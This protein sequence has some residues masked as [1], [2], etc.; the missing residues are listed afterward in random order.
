MARSMW[1]LFE[2][3]HAV[4][5]FAAEAR[6]AYEQAGLRGFWRGYF[7]GRAAPLGVAGAGGTV[8]APAGT[9]TA[10]AGTAGAA[11][12]AA[13][14][15]NFA[16]A[17]VARAIPGVWDLITPE[18]ALRVRLAGATEGLGRLLAGQEAEAAAA[19]DLLWRAIGELDF[20]GR[21]LAAANAALPVL[22]GEDVAVSSASSASLAAAA[23]GRLWQAATLLREH[24]GDGHFA[25][26]AAADIDGCEAVVLRCCL[27]LR[28]EDMQPVRG[29]TDEAWDG[30]LS[31]LAAR[32]WV[33]A[34]GVL[35]SAGREAHAAVE[36]A[37]D[38]AA[39][40]PWARLGPEATAEIAAALTPLAR[41]C[42]AALPYP[43]PI[44][45]PAPGEG[46][47]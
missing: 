25:A 15:F 3:I 30:A 33:G 2:P 37:T 44:G 17:F 13:S 5:Y 41:A 47:S 32:G 35:T 21:V 11:V 12:V 38:R 8:T 27:D 4:T 42:A 6:S 16:P 45:V 29:W 14:F 34:D 46:R 28:R 24:R 43:S 7:A 10:P 26:L 23:L 20:S 40:R 36:D 9:V 39:S 18:E 31:R 22:P 19:G 1:T